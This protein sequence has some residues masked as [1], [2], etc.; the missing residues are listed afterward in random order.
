M[1]PPCILEFQ[2]MKFAVMGGQLFFCGQ[3]EMEM[4]PVPWDEVSKDENDVTV[5]KKVQSM[6]EGTYHE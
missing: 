2:G 4:R 1:K 5:L 3:D 6:L